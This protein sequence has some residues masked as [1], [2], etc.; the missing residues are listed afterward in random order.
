VH[1]ADAA[2]TMIYQTLQEATKARGARKVKIINLGLDPAEAR[3]M[4][5]AVEPV[6]SN[7]RDRPVADY[8]PESDREWLQSHRTEL[9]AMTMP[10][11]IDWLDAKMKFYEGKVVP[12][13]DVLT[14]QLEE[15]TQRHLQ[16]KITRRILRKARIPERVKRAFASMEQDYH[17]ALPSLEGVI[18]NDLGRN[19]VQSWRNVVSRLAKRLAR[20]SQRQRSRA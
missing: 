12:P 11:F 6:E 9:N 19:R 3:E 20:G 18:K 13:Q 7:D 17:N 4:G 1:D 5:L 16:D 15:E 14:T 10:Q 2:G 8:V